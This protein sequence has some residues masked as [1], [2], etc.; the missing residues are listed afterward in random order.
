MPRPQAADARCTPEG[1]GRSARLTGGRWGQAEWTWTEWGH[2][3]LP[4]TPASD[5]RL[6]GPSTGRGQG[7]DVSGDR[8][9]PD[10]AGAERGDGPASDDGTDGGEGSDLGRPDRTRR[11]GAPRACAPRWS[12]RRPKALTTPGAGALATEGREVRGLRPEDRSDRD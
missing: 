12:P 10:D 5:R 8:P 7:A 6:S 3:T 9:G 1:P 11:G 2:A 4:T